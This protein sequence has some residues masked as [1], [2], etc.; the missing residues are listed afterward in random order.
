MSKL[1]TPRGAGR[2]AQAGI[3]VFA[4][5]CI[6]W[7]FLRPDL[8]WIETPLSLYLLGPAGWGLQVAYVALAAALVALAL[9]YYHRL[10]RHARSAA[11]VLLFAIGAAALVVTALA[12][13]NVPTAPPTLEGWV[14]G[15][16]ASTAFLTV[17]T[18]MLLQSWWLRGLPGPADRWKLAM[19]LAAVCFVGLWLHV[20]WRELPRGAGQKALV[21]LIVAWLGLAAHWLGQAD[22]CALAE[23]KAGAGDRGWPARGPPSA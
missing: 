14:H 2:A 8:D 4:L 20:L 9:G 18:A 13:S 3:A 5:A 19:V 6:A 16:A 12:R 7:Q 1:L 21:A 11:P 15:T 22:E 23:C 17:T 10:P